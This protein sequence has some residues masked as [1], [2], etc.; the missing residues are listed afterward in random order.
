MFLQ[1]FNEFFF[2][3]TLAMMFRYYNRHGLR[4]NP[5]VLAWLLGRRPTSFDEFVGS[6]VKDELRS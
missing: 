3:T 2:E 4:G 5:N 6:V 1:K